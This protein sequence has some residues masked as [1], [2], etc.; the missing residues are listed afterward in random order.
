[1]KTI[2]LITFSLLI[3]FNFQAQAEPQFENMENSRSRVN[4]VAGSMFNGPEVGAGG[5]TGSDSTPTSCPP[6]PACPSTPTL[7]VTNHPWGGYDGSQ[8]RTGVNNGNV[9]GTNNGMMAN[10]NGR[11][12]GVPGPFVAVPGGKIFQNFPKLLLKTLFILSFFEELFLIIM[13]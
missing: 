3:N 1:M 8:I 5:G 2:G 7:K 4:N 10:N 9:A 12:G 13:F 11:E 6:C